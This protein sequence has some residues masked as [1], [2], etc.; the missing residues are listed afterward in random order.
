[1]KFSTDEA[2]KWKLEPKIK[3]Q[4]SLR[5]NQLIFS[6][7]NLQVQWGMSERWI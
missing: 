6:N 4:K 5:V 2:K 3:R 1:M 7:S